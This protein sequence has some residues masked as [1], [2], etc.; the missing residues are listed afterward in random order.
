MYEKRG[1]LIIFLLYLFS[2]PYFFCIIKTR[3]ILKTILQTLKTYFILSVFHLKQ[4]LINF[5]KIKLKVFSHPLFSLCTNCHRLLCR[6]FGTFCYLVQFWFFFFLL[7]LFSY[8]FCFSFGRDGF[9][10]VAAH[11]TLPIDQ[12]HC[13]CQ[14]ARLGLRRVRGRQQLDPFW[15]CLF[16]I[17]FYANGEHFALSF[18]GF[19]RTEAESKRGLL[20][21]ITRHRFLCMHVCIIVSRLQHTHTHT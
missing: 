16:P 11:S 14:A 7:F 9:D 20:L 5:P 19:S 6:L 10:G 3:Y 8:V 2:T 12:R 1:L 4:H 15:L 17:I 18:R 13:H 21:T